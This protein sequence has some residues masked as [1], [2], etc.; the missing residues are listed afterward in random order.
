VSYWNDTHWAKK[1]GR[2]GSWRGERKWS[3]VAKAMLTGVISHGPTWSMRKTTK[4][5]TESF[6]LGLR[7]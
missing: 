7:A 1:P 5:F 3:N 2:I 4:S 6:T